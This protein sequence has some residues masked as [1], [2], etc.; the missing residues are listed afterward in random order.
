MQWSLLL[1]LHAVG[2]CSAKPLPRKEK[3]PLDT[4]RE[5]SGIKW[6]LAWSDV[7]ESVALLSRDR[8]AS[9]RWPRL[10]KVHL[11]MSVKDPR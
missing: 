10:C 4:S 3:I 1:V 9:C 6:D 5:R 11:M 2:G 7:P 8:L